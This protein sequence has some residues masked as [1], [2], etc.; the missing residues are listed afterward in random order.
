MA[1]L[2]HVEIDIRAPMEAV[3]ARLSD[4]ARFREFPGIAASALL[5]EGAP[6]RNGVGALRMIRASGGV[7]FE[8]RI[9]A[10]EP[11]ERYAYRIVKCT[12][13][14]EH[15]G[16]EVRL[17]DRGEAVRVVWRSEFATRVPLLGGLAR[18][19]GERGF[20]AI[21]RAVKRELE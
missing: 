16:G 5:T 20:M 14:L 6:D 18:R 2:V 13:P 8:E 10:F 3:F 19:A 17:H 15:L 11:P 7:R 12:L 4:H 1:H 9:E 21:L